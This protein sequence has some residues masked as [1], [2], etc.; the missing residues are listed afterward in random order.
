MQTNNVREISSIAAHVASD[1]NHHIEESVLNKINTCCLA[2]GARVK[3]PSLFVTISGLTSPGPLKL[4][5]PFKSFV[6]SIS[7]IFRTSRGQPM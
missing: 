4:W 2:S 7:Y 6:I 5:N 1:R 3:I